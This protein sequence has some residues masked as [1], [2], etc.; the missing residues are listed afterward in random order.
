MQAEGTSFVIQSDA[1]GTYLLTNKH[2]VEGATPKTMVAISPDGQVTYNVLAIRQNSAD[3]GT[4][5]DIA[6]VKLQPT[7][8]RPLTWGDSS[9]LRLLQK[10]ISMGYG[11]AFDLPGPPSVTEGAI[12]ALNRDLGDGFGGVWIQHQ[13]FINGGNSGGPLLDDTYHV[14]GINTLSLK[15][16]QGIFFAIPSNL[17]R[18]TAGQLIASMGG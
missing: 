5:G 8:L 16:T 18:Q 12:S 7:S 9:K 2:V 11:D 15:D 14:V 3:T 13:S 4:P 10:V 1:S 6:I 17:A